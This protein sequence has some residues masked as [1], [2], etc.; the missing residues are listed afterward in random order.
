M[1][2]TRASGLRPR[3]VRPREGRRVAGVAAAIGAAAGIDPNLV[4]IAFVV[5]ALAGGAG[6][7]LYAAGWLVLPSEGKSAALQ[8]VTSPKAGFDFGRALALVAIV[9]GTLLLLSNVHIVF[10]DSIVWPAAVGGIGVALLWGRVRPND[11]TRERSASAWSAVVASLVGERRR[12]ASIARVLVGAVLVIGATGA[13]VAATNAVVARRAFGAVVVMALGLALVFG[14]WLWRLGN[15]LT[16]ERAERIRSQ[17]R[18]EVAAHLHDSVLHTLALVRRNADD[19]KHVAALARRQERELRSWLAG[20]TAAVH[21]DSLGSALDEAAADVESDHGVPVEIV[22]VGDCSL[23]EHL[24][25]LVRAAREAIVNA[26]KHSGA[27][28]VAVYM[29]VDNG[30]AAVFVRDR[31]VGFDPDD[32]GADRHGLAESITG[33]MRRHDGQAVIRSTPGTGT[34]VQLTMPRAHA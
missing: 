14:P 8:I 4:R 19:P 5:L 25:A 22:K 24:T 34:E 7:A 20:K 16:R 17:E 29:E 27:D 9:L 12:P 11:H 6:I 1:Q 18:A 26:A 10:V 32:V 30:T 33:R 15:D 21:A 2:A 31:G 23:D 13:V 3:A 28:S